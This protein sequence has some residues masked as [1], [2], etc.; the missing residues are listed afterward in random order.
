MR[1][2]QILTL[3]ATTAVIAFGQSNPPKESFTIVIKAETAIVKA[4]SGVPIN[5][6]LTNVSNR[7]IDASGCYCGPSGLDSYLTWDVRD[8]K[9]HLAAKKIYS[10][11]ELAT[12]SAILD[13]IILRA[14]A[15]PKTKTSAVSTI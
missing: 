9:G 10:H 7:P 3:I 4:G 11:P 6:R 2:F 1:F 14:R 5:G 8:D 15:L 12:G 13:R